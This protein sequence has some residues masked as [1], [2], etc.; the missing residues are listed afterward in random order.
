MKLC[1]FQGMG[2]LLYKGEGGRPTNYIK[3]KST[4]VWL[5]NDLFAPPS[6]GRKRQ[7]RAQRK[8]CPS[9]TNELKVGVALLSSVCIE[10]KA[11]RRWIV[12]FCLDVCC[13]FAPI[14]GSIEQ[15]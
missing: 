13:V 10:G 5:I 7:R 8:R 9:T 1:I 3:D 4:I 12:W 11:Q 15:F 6:S 14:Y 2:A